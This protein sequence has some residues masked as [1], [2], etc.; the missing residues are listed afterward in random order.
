MLVSTVQKGRVELDGNV[1]R[2]DENNW[3]DIGSKF[4]R[5]A[6]LWWNNGKPERILIVKKHGSRA[7]LDKLK[8]VA[9]W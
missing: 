1:N 3:L 4:R 8:D 9:A 2:D 6:M 5:R 7:A